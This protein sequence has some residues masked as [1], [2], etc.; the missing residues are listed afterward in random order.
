MGER[1]ARGHLLDYVVTSVPIMTSGTTAAAA[2]EL[3]RKQRFES[4]EHVLIADTAARFVGA[5]ALTDIFLASPEAPIGGLT[6][7]NVAV[8]SA[9]MD[10]E[11]A[12]SAAVRS[13]IAALAVCDADGRLLGAVTAH[14]LMAIL[15]DEQSKTSTRWQAS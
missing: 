14:S 12:A 13:G 15:R 3:L 9:A 6:A 11:D 5:V 4:T 2:L 10:R 1:V 8:V 7:A